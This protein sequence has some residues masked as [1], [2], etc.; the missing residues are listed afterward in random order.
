NKIS[1]SCLLFRL[2]K[3]FHL[4][5]VHLLLD[6]V[7][8]IISVL[9]FLIAINFFICAQA[10]GFQRTFGGQLIENGFD[11]IS[12]HDGG[13]A[14]TGHSN[15]FTNGDFDVVLI[16]L[17]SN[18]DL[19]W[20]RTYG[21]GGGDEALQ[22]VETSD[23]GFA[24]SGKTSSFGSGNY[25]AMLIKTDSTGNVVWLKAF[26]GTAEERILN[27]RETSDHGF[28]LAGSTHSFGQG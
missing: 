9:F 11:I 1:V 5:S 8:K 24:I 27:L 16:K 12:T 21:G 14:V 23:H 6:H 18:A 10:P 25:D 4:Q 19:L 13:Y 20:S 17:D 28:I 22:L 26:S 3:N 15:S 7:K 2:V